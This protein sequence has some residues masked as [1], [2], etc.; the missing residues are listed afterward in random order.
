MNHVNK[1][2][3]F[4]LIE[5]MLAMAFVAFLLVAIAMTVIQ[6][7]NIYNRGLA[8]KNINQAGRSIV[9]ELKRGIGQSSKFS[10][11]STD[12]DNQF[13]NIGPNKGGRLCL[14]SVSYIWNYGEAINDGL[15]IRNT[16]VNNNGDI[17]FVKVL[18]PTAE[19]CKNPSK[20]IDPTSKPVELLNPG[21]YNLVIHKFSIFGSTAG[22]VPVSDNLTKQQLYNIQFII[23]TNNQ[24]ALITDRSSCKPPSEAGSDLNYC[25]VNEFKITARAG[26]K[27]E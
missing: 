23:G 7:G 11:V 27:S 3:G 26:N 8:L 22:A 2:K 17:R 14:G 24:A 16:Y 15:A 6:I 21:Q 19:Y 20:K 9:D 4:T 5:L 18:D 10:I 13:I 12:S 25:A 1:T